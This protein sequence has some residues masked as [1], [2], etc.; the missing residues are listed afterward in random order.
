[1]RYGALLIGL[2]GTAAAVPLVAGFR[3][4]APGPAARP[5]AP[6][7]GTVAYRG[8]RVPV[9]AGWE[10]HRLD[11]DPDRCVRFDRH[12][13][14]LGGPGPRPDCP[15][16][17]IGGTEA[18]WIEP[19]GG[20]SAKRTGAVRADRLARHTVQ[21]TGAHE[22]RLALPEAGVTITGTYGTD[23][24]ALQ[25]TLRATRLTTTWP[26]EPVPTS[27]PTEAPEPTTS[28]SAGD[29]PDAEPKSGQEAPLPNWASG[30]GFDICAA[31]AVSTMKAW[32]RAYGIANIY[33]GGAARG[34]AQPNL[35]RAWVRTVRR[36]GYRL[37]PTY[38]GLQAPC[39]KYKSRITAANAA[40]EGADAA[41]DAVRR[42]RA[43]GIPRRQPLY[44]DIEGYDTGDD[45]CSEAV[46]S[47][48][49]SWTTKLKAAR[50]VPGV[51]S[52]LSSGIR[53]L[54]KARG[55]T[56]PTAIWFA[57]WDGDTAV[58]DTPDLP[59]EWWPPHRR[60][61]QY[62]GGHKEKHGGVTLNVDSNAV[63][64]RVY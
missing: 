56:K 59:D 29:A 1:M 63:D 31:P 2:L 25:R 27:D 5:S 64:G 6:L 47:F 48:L 35:T 41:E 61:K 18:L 13:I 39:S 10:V 30:E 14:Y 9:P 17:V 50:Y 37:I 40:A 34:C 53:D 36:M 20:A 49:D 28:G 42:A 12:A 21:A 7:T 15:A 38:V 19:L 44:F 54:G 46:M 62:R 4:S 16:R 52:S 24:A 8:V 3:P 60:I 23:P 51:Y 45:A 26:D 58:Y 57:H 11:R 32:R 33:I 22:E 55:I 43:L